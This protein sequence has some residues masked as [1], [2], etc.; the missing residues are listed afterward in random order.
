[1]TDEYRLPFHAS[2]QLW[3]KLKPL[4]R[5]MRHAHTLAEDVLWQRLRNRRIQGAKF[6]RQYAI[7]RFIV[8][9]VCLDHCLVIEVDGSV[10]EQQQEVDAIR[11][12]FLEEQG[13]RVLRFTND[14]VLRSLEGVLDVVHETLAQL[15]G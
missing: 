2:P 1:M 11:Q 8:D 4:A 5:E 13:F 15:Q 3:E 6:R 9:F 7:E 14:E 12:E 10:H